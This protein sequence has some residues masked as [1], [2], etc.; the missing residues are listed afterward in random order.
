MK[1][2]Q[3]LLLNPIHFLSLGF[4]T[5][6]SPYAPGTMGSVAAVPLVYFMLQ[7]PLTFYLGLT[8]IAFILGC[9]ICQFTATALASNDPAEVVWDE[10]VGFMITMIAAPA[11]W[12]WLVLGFVLFRLFDIVKPWPISMVERR[13]G[14]GFGIMIDDVLAGFFAFIILQLS[15]RIPF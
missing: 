15:A 7:L 4:G 6:L 2:K 8:L 1:S 10:I 13:C 14:G 5:G 12:L 11:G 3:S 9:W